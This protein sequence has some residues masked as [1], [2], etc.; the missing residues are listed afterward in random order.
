MW[1]S[2]Q[3]FSSTSLFCSYSRVVLASLYARG[4]VG[5]PSLRS[6]AFCGRFYLFFPLLLEFS[7]FMPARRSCVMIRLIWCWALCIMP[8]VQF[9]FHLTS[10]LEDSITF[11]YKSFCQNL[12]MSKELWSSVRAVHDHNVF[13]LLPVLFLHLDRHTECTDDEDCTL[14][15]EITLKYL[16]VVLA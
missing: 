7:Q 4:L 2:S 3:C 11:S 12:L 10:K 1:D 8:E 14:H 9:R 5:P 6:L 13:D 15:L 16:H